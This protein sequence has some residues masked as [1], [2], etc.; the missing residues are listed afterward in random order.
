MA[1]VC[2]Q[3][4]HFALPRQICAMPT[5]HALRMKGIE[6]GSKIGF[7]LRRET[8]GTRGLFNETYTSA[9]IACARPRARGAR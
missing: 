6:F 7:I 1:F 8:R 4:F 2:A 5:G 9:V 3:S